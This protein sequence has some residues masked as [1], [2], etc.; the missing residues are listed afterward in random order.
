MSR[1]IAFVIPARVMDRDP[2]VPQGGCSWSPPEP[3]LYV[4][5][6]LIL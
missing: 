4:Y 5:V 1:L 2:V 3:D 6:L